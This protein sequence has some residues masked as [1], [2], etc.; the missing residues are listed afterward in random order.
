ME[1]EEQTALTFPGL[2]LGVLFFL[3]LLPG[4]FLTDLSLR[5]ASDLLLAMANGDESLKICAETSMAPNRPSLTAFAY[6]CMHACMHAYASCHMPMPM[7]SRHAYHG[8]GMRACMR[9]HHATCTYPCI[10]G[11]HTTENVCVLTCVRI[12]PHARTHA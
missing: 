7:H 5:K 8:A 3:I 1:R 9:T 10:A 12:M 2:L 11:M 4:F 6:V